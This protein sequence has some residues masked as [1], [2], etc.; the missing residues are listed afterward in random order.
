MSAP[1]DVARML[2]MVPWLLQRPGASLTEIAEAFGVDE[3]TVRGDLDHLDFCGLPGLGGGDLFEVMTVG[4]RVVLRMAEELARPMRPTASEA[5]RLV[6][7]VDAVADLLD[8]ELPALR[9]AL[10]KV[11]AALGIPQSAAD[12][13]GPSGPATLSRLRDA[14]R[15]RR[16]VQL[17]YQGRA[18]TAPQQR[19]VDPW[20]LHVVD[21][22]WYLQGHDHGAG[23]RRV[24]RLDRIGSVTTTDQPVTVEAPAQLEPPRYVPED[25]HLAVVLE[26]GARGRWIN[27]ALSV[28][29]V[30]ELDDGGA[31]L[32]LRTDA[33]GWLARLVVMA[34]GEARVVEPTQLREQVATIAA[35]ALERYP[36]ARA[37]R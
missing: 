22:S 21:G 34:A 15:D 19:E 20:A 16:R 26:V 29:E 27:D 4:D 6:L 2:T 7:T 5:M 11:R 13:V 33:P 32:R 35:A 17:T 9:S 25:D 1:D 37:G 23:A 3:R 28:D 30:E 18:D 12:V 31:R 36:E 8:D 10:D 24:F 14:V